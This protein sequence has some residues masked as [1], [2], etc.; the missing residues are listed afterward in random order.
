MDLTLIWALIIA[1]GV[2]MYIVLDGFDLGV[3]I[4]FP[5]APTEDDRDI[6]MASIAP[7]WD[8][9][10]TWLVLGGAALF[11]AF[12]LAY[13][14]LLPALYVPLTLFLIGLIFRGVAFEF[15]AKAQT[16]KQAWNLSFAGGSA[17]ATFA[18]GVVLGSFIQGF[19]VVDGRPVIEPFGWLTPFSLATGAALMAGYALLGATWLLL[20]TKGDLQGWCYRA[21]LPLTV[22]VLAAI[23]AVSLWTPFAQP[24]I[25]ARWFAMP[26][27]L[28]LLPIPAVT[29]G[30]GLAL[31]L[32]IRYRREA[33]AFPCA[34]GLF[35]LSYAGLAVSLWPYAVPRSITIWQAAAPP[36]SQLFLLVGV[37]MF[38]P[39]VAGYTLYSYYTFR[40]KVRPEDGYH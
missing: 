38:L 14:L 15:R 16:S 40:G 3:G 10:E 27:F 37:L 9:N 19:P 12:P 26:Q 6:M 34:V 1:L 28:V 22:A 5:F 17:L 31:I 23:V 32:A 7:V 4:L 36:E 8:G 2:I 13:S 33:L 20:K 39:L 35:L 24:D 18:Q 25:A 11:G 29:A 30:V 21:A